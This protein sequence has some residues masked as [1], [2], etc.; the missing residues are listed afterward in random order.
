MAGNANPISSLGNYIV[1]TGGTHL[2]TGLRNA[3]AIASRATI[4]GVSVSRTRG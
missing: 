2:P 4:V 3:L 1:H